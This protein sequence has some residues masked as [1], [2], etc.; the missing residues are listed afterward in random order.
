M[1][2]RHRG[3]RET[4]GQE[5]RFSKWAELFHLASSG[6]SDRV[7]PEIVVKASVVRPKQRFERNGGARRACTNRTEP[8]GARPKSDSEDAPFLELWLTGGPE[9]HQVLH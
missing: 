6:G 3:T 4:W 9:P 1:G 7:H 2:S 8:R 5:N